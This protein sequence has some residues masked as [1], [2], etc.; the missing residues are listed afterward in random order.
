MHDQLTRSA[1]HSQALWPYRLL[2]VASIVL[3]ALLFAVIAV[4]D[5]RNVAETAEQRAT[6]ASEILYQHALNVFETH[7][8]AAMRVDEHIRGMSWDD[9]AQSEAL[10]QWLRHITETY[11]QVEIDLA[12]GWRGQYP[13]RERDFSDAGDQCSRP[14]LF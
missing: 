9:I 14:R 1:K 6:A 3:P 13:E 8:L 2:M 5:R 11:P 4:V 7:E 10:H 12:R